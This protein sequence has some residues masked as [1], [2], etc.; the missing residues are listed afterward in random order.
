MLLAGILYDP[1]DERSTFVSLSLNQDDRNAFENHTQGTYVNHIV[2]ELMIPES[3]RQE[4]VHVL[5]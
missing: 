3:K 2:L 5:D 1:L 4:K